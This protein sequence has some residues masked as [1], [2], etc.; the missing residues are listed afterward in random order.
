MLLGDVTLGDGDEAREARLRGQQI[1]V[2]GVG[3]AGLVAFAGAIANREELSAGV[4]KEGEVHSIDERA[5]ARGQSLQAAGQVGGPFE[6]LCVAGVQDLVERRRQFL[7]PVE[8]FPEAGFATE[9]LRR[10]RGGGGFELGGRE[11]FAKGFPVAA[12]EGG[13]SVWEPSRHRPWLQ[14]QLL[15]DLGLLGQPDEGS[16]RIAREAPAGARWRA[17][18]RR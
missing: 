14:Q 4:I 7:R 16:N 5:G 8:G 13:L 12:E 9:G 1:V 10:G 11:R 6:R 2:R 3:P 18:R 17:R 15:E